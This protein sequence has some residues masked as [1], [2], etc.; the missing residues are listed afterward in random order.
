MQ[1]SNYEKITNLLSTIS[2]MMDIMSHDGTTHGD[3]LKNSYSSMEKIKNILNE[4][5]REEQW[6]K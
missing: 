5:E 2:M 1:E 4:M 3:M 6:E